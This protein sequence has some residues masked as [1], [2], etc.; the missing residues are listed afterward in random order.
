[1]LARSWL[2]WVRKSLQRFMNG[3]S[4]GSDTSQMRV[5]PVT[6]SM[7]AFLNLKDFLEVNRAEA[8]KVS[9]YEYN[10]QEHMRM[11]REDAFE[12]GRKVGLDEGRKLGQEESLNLI[13]TLMNKM[14][15]DG[16]G[17]QLSRLADDPAFY[18]E[19]LKK[20]L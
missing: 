10:E 9:I 20:Y 6:L 14:A 18:Q 17:D 12:D 11:E 19:M 4:N 16:L 5:T 1:M 15:A 8:M 7:N 3:N 13:F 2:D